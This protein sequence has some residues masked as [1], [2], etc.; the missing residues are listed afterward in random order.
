MLD[1]DNKNCLDVCIERGE[2][3]IIKL[4]LNDPNWKLLFREDNKVN[5]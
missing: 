5:F 3:N 2:E 4:L 1:T